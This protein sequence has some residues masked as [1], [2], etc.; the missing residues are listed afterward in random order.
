MWSGEVQSPFLEERRQ[1]VQTL[2][3]GTDLSP[4]SE[5][6]RVGSGHWKGFAAMPLRT[7][8]NGLNFVNK[9][10]PEQGTSR[11]LA[12]SPAM[13]SSYASSFSLPGPSWRWGRSFNS[14]GFMC[15]PEFSAH[16]GGCGWMCRV[17]GLAGEKGGKNPPLW[18][19]GL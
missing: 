3:L 8:R 11:V 17:T 19:Q 13:G 5:S 4:P 16:V 14:A 15:E 6:G 2:S 18:S 1:G 9:T 10:S 7:E 12:E